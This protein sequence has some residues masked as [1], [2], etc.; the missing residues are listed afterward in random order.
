MLHVLLAMKAVRVEVEEAFDGEGATEA[1]GPDGRA[2]EPQVRDGEAESLAD[3]EVSEA[4]AESAK[5]RG[6]R[7]NGETLNYKKMQY[8]HA[9]HGHW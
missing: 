9:G 8:H 6:R 3:E 1:D 7:A 5:P 2:T 4:S